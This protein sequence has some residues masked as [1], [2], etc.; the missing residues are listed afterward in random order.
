VLLKVQ[1]GKFINVDVTLTYYYYWGDRISVLQNVQT[2]SRVHP[3]SYAVGASVP[4]WGRGVWGVMLT[5]QLLL[6]TVRMSGTVLVLTL[7]VMVWTGLTLLF[8]FYRWTV[9]V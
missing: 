7:C 3:A 1:D 8:T 5:I 9:T 4:F 2:G 6:L